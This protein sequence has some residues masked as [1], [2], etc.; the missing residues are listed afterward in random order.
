VPPI[1][2]SY[3]YGDLVAMVDDLPAVGRWGSPTPSTFNISIT[4]LDVDY[5][6]ILA[7]EVEQL[8]FQCT[9]PV[10]AVAGLTTLEPSARFSVMFPNTSTFSNYEIQTVSK[11][12]DDVA[13]T[14]ILKSDRRN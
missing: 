5:Q 4:Q 13:Y 11:S 1:A 10:L 7:G 12:A 2:T 3:W 9:F 6:L 14:L 8:A